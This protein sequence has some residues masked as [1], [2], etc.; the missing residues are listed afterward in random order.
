MLSFKEY[1]LIEKAYITD[2]SGR[3][4]T[5]RPISVN[6]RNINV[7]KRELSKSVGKDVSA[8][9][10]DVD[11]SLRQLRGLYDIRN[12]NIYLMFST[13]GIHL[14]ILDEFNI[15]KNNRKNIGKIFKLF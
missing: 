5:A 12:G 15:P 6:A 9:Y 2:G 13:D 11:E 8:A 1:I 3:Y 7:A 10:G 4:D 14:L